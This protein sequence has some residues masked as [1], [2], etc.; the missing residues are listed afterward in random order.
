[1]AVRPHDS[2]ARSLEPTHGGHDRMATDEFPPAP[3]GRVHIQPTINLRVHVY[4]QGG[5]WYAASTDLPLMAEGADEQEAEQRFYDMAIAYLGSAL[6]HG[7][8]EAINRR[9]SF[10]RRV[11]IRRRVAIARLR[12]RHPVSRN[13]HLEL[14]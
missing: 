2:D 6:E 12:R 8:I 4:P 10:L 13:Q 5:R 14:A 3:A 1:M 9:P 7:W 11:E